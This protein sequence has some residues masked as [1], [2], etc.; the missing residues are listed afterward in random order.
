MF[1]LRSIRDG[2]RELVLS[3]IGS[4]HSRT[5]QLTAL[6]TLDAHLLNDIGITQEEAS[7]GFA[8]HKAAPADPKD[9]S[10]RLE[11]RRPYLNR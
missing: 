10:V 6:R 9:R 4:P 1:T 2:I 8:L 7:R 5:R 3:C 11:I